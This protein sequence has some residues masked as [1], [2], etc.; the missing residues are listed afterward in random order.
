MRAAERPAMASMGRGWSTA[1]ARAPQESHDDDTGADRPSGPAS[2]SPAEPAAGAKPRADGLELPTSVLH[3]ADRLT[4]EVMG[5]LGPASAVLEQ[6][7]VVQVLITAAGDVPADGTKPTRADASATPAPAQTPARPPGLATSVEWLAPAAGPRRL[8]TWRR[9]QRATA[10]LA[11]ALQASP[12][13]AVHVHGFVAALAAGLALRGRAGIVYYSP[14]GSASLGRWRSLGSALQWL[15]R[16]VTGTAPFDRVITCCAV[17][18]RLLPGLGQ[19]AQV[20]KVNRHAVPK[21]Q[22]LAHPQVHLAESPVARCFHVQARWP[23]PEPLVL[24]GVLEEGLPAAERAARLAVLL[25]D[26]EVRARVRWVGTVQPETAPLLRAAGIDAAPPGDDRSLAARFAEAWVF[27]APVATTRFPLLLA[28][29]MA[30]QLPCV[31]LDSPFNAAL[32]KDGHNGFLCK[33]LEQMLE[34]TREL[35][36]YPALRERIGRAARREAARRF[37]EGLFRQAVLLGYGAP[38][39]PPVPARGFA[40]RL[41]GRASP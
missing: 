17:E 3:L 13:A 10:A 24:A 38:H 6:A 23:A 39:R 30:A 19:A 31:A 36:E 4:P 11:S 15:A 37:D 28:Q 12:Q 7:G 9:W 1:L 26:E 40:W 32:L 34:R 20:S 8:S 25:G 41:A 5:F 16:A 33:D 14:H 27:V 2:L 18:S 22:P 21:V 29:A 35:I